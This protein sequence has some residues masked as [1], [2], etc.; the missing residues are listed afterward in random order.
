MTMIVG[1]R[2]PRI[3]QDPQTLT[4]A[5]P[6][7]VCWSSDASNS[8]MPC[9]GATALIASLLRFLFPSVPQAPTGAVPRSVVSP[10]VP[11]MLR[12]GAWGR[13]PPHPF[14]KE[15]TYFP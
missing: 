4:R 10:R 7:S 8:R 12:T 6:W 2:E 13:Q 14:L 3:I 15:Q 5:Q 1:L 9:K 11:F